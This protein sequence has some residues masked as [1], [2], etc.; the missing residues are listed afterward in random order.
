[1]PG[2]PASTTH[3][4]APPER[5][6]SP[7]PPWLTAV[8]AWQVV[9][10]AGAVLGGILI[11]TGTLWNLSGL[12][13][14]LVGGGLVVAGI[15]SALGAMDMWAH[16]HRGRAIGTMVS[17]LVAFGFVFVALQN[18]GVFV[19]LDALGDNFR[20]TAWVLIVIGAGWILVTQS[21]RFG[22][23][24]PTVRTVGK[25]VTIAGAAWLLI[26]VGLFQGILEFV[27]RLA[28]VDVFVPL[29]VG[30]VGGVAFW[31]LRRD[32][33]AFLFKTTRD[34]AEAMDGFLFASPNVIGFLAFFAGPLLFSLYV[35]FTSWDG[36]TDIQWI[37]LDNYA[38]IFGLQFTS[39]DDGQ[40][41]ADV[42][43]T[44]YTELLRWGDFIIGARERLFWVGLRNIFVFG[45]VA[46]PL[47]VFPALLLAALL[48]QK[49]PGVKFFRAVYFIPSVAGVVGIALIWKQMY[50]ATVGF[51]NYGIVRFFDLINLLPGV[52]F[53]APQ[54][55]WL[56]N[57]RVALF[58]VVIVFAWMTIGFNTVLYLA[59]MQGISSSLYEAASIDGA[60]AWAK[61]WRI[62]V[63][64]LRP[65]TLFV[66][67]TTT[68]LALQLFNEPFILFNPQQQPSGPNNSTLTPVIQ[69][70]Q[71]GFQRFNQG[72]ASALAWVLFAIIFAITILYF[73]RQEDEVG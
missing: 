19:G 10:A 28:E 1:M 58:S 25:W 8:I 2:E 53:T 60:G 50:N 5:P 35:S 72:F 7:T 26:G 11:F 65:T 59:G 73:R 38:R 55:E 27:I 6:P 17:Y 32:E 63:P 69:L 21:E 37:G 61:F 4:E 45:I 29:L 68:I 46:V 40:L 49:L 57:S 30:I 23:A 51:I 52:D 13:L 42:L 64:M 44:N 24:E 67:A 14:V 3:V 66:V 34:Q 36:L 62:T 15:V 18:M 22:S 70:Y 43:K 39:I 71:E 56:S 12:G 54:P 47:S 41:A 31:V 9:V 33:A 16:R 20:S 48:N